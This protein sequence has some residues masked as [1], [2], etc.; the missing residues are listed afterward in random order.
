[1][2]HIFNKL[3]FVEFFPFFFLL[4][5][6]K[7]NSRNT[8]VLPEGAISFLLVSSHYLQNIHKEFLFMLHVIH[9]NNHLLSKSSATQVT[10]SKSNEAIASCLKNYINSVITMHEILNWYYKT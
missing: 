6:T 7:E 3:L 2:Q 1:M 10:Y 4:L 5:F 9:R 8:P